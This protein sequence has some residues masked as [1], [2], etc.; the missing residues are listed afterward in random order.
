MVTRGK[1]NTDKTSAR[2]VARLTVRALKRSVPSAV[3]GIF[4]LS[5]G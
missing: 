4:F 1:S 2:E 3:P 5:G